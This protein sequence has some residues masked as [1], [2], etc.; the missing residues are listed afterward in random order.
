MFDTIYKSLEIAMP[1]GFKG[2][3]KLAKLFIYENKGLPPQGKE[4]NNMGPAHLCFIKLHL[5]LS[6]NVVL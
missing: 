3:T 4:R 2:L 1:T 6:I 5:S